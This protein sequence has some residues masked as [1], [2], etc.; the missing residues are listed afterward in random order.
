MST[1][2]MGLIGPLLRLTHKQK[3]R[4]RTSLVEN[5]PPF[6][7]LSTGTPSLSAMKP[8]IVKMTKPAKRLVPQLINETIYVSLKEKKRNKSKLTCK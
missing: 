4:Q 2:I 7:T 1:C 3:N 6:T 5:I 8:I